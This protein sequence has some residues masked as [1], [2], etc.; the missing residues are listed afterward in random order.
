MMKRMFIAVAL[1]ALIA[2]AASAAE[3]GRFTME[4]DEDNAWLPT[5][6][7]FEGAP[8]VELLHPKLGL[9]HS[10][11][12][13]E[14]R[15]KYYREENRN[16]WGERDDPRFVV[17]VKP[18]ATREAPVQ[19]NGYTGE[20]VAYESSY[21]NIERSIL[22]HANEPRIKIV[23]DIDPSREMVVN[24]ANMFSVSVRLEES[25]AVAEMLD[26]RDI[27]GDTLEYAGAQ[28]SGRLYN[29]GPVAFS[30]PENNIAAL[31]WYE[32]S[33]QFPNRMI[34]LQPGEDFTLTLNIQLF[35][36]DRDGLMAAM[37]ERRRQM[38]EEE[39][40]YCLYAT[41]YHVLYRLNDEEEGEAILN[42]VADMKPEWYQPYMMIAE[43]RLQNNIQGLVRGRTMAEYY[44]EA[45][46][47]NPTDYGVIL[48]GL[49]YLEDDRLTE[50]QKR[51]LLFNLMAVMEHTQFYPEYYVWMARQFESRRMYAQACAIYRQALWA[52]DHYPVSERKREQVRARMT[53][54][55]ER[56]EKIL[57]EE[58]FPD[59]PAPI[60]VRPAEDEDL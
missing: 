41:G 4:A 58:I 48:R 16:V 36:D 47:R 9:N 34:R 46:F 38:G 60:E 10:F 7:K 39:A 52:T 26:E 13:Y 37:R 1:M 32:M 15:N 54:N 14:F 35:Q 30:D 59:P 6:I 3:Y 40:A 51:L 49:G 11:T 22:F 28:Y 44:Q 50:E 20:S 12:S 17:D 31:V 23:Y 25:F 43:Y 55:I 8:D 27:D 2:T 18:G 42:Q 5:S 56:L 29:S 24:A 53:Q 45:A 19:M 57:L 21:A 33:R